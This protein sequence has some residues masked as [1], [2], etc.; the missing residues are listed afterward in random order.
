MD[1][2]EMRLSSGSVVSCLLTRFL[3]TVNVKGLCDSILHIFAMPFI[4]QLREAALL[5]DR[6]R[7]EARFSIR[8]RGNLAR[9]SRRAVPLLLRRRRQAGLAFFSNTRSA[10]LL[11]TANVKWVAAAVI[12]HTACIEKCFMISN[13][14]TLNYY[15][16]GQP[17][18]RECR[19]DKLRASSE[20]WPWG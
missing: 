12:N 18:W 9:E 14:L 2:I 3:Q 16:I 10:V 20:K 17:T 7:P 6:R 15:S 11:T 4:F 8:Q 19:G 1:K 5:E 13:Q